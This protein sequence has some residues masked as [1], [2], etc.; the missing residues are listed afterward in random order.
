LAVQY[1]PQRIL[2]RISRFS[3]YIPVLSASFSI[4]AVLDEIFQKRQSYREY[5]AAMVR[6][7]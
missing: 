1:I 5:V 4:M 3:E 2:Q 7:T 6:N